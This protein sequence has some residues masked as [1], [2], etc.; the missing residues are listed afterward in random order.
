MATLAPNHPA[1]EAWTSYAAASA[2]DHFVWWCEEHCE[3]SIDQFAG[4]PLILEP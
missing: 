4:L 3:Q 2:I 1:A